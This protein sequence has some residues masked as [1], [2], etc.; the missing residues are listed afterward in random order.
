MAASEPRSQLSFVRCSR[1]SMG[2]LVSITPNRKSTMT[3]PM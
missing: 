1:P 3:A 2:A